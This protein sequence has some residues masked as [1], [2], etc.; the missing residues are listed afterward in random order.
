MDVVVTDTEWGKLWVKV[1]LKNS[2]TFIPSFEDLFRIIQAI[3]YC[4]D[5]KYP[6]GKGREMVEEFLKDCVHETNYAELA[7]KYEIP[8]REWK[9]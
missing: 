5:R 9:E 7:E 2:Q 4:E 8:I 1:T 6:N 3:C